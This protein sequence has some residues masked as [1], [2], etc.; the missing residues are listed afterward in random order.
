MIRP[1]EIKKSKFK[2]KKV[3]WHPGDQYT[4]SGYAL[5]IEVEGSTRPQMVHLY[6]YELNKDWVEEE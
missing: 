2:I 5:L 1:I 6:G 4:E 3:V